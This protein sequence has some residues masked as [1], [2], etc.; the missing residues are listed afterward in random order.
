MKTS[1]PGRRHD[2]GFSLIEVMVAIVIL[3]VGVAGLT[4]GLNTA[5]GSSKESELQTAAALLAAGQIEMLRAD[6]YIIAGDDEGEGGTGL[7]L[8]RWRQ[9]IVET[10]PPGLFEVTVTVEHAKT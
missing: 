6:V 9:S 8:Y 5:V 4:H 10:T 3:G 1:F 2:V 7:E